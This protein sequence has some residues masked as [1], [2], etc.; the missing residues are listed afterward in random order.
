MPL[1]KKN[2]TNADVG[3]GIEA[4]KEGLAFPEDVALQVIVP[5]NIE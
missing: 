2:L 3:F 1:S 5:T 4:L